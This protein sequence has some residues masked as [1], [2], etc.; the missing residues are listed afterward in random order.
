[1][2]KVFESEFKQWGKNMVKTH[3]FEA[4]DKEEWIVYEG[5]IDGGLREI[6]QLDYAKDCVLMD[7]EKFRSYSFRYV[8]P[9]IIVTETAVF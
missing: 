5:L 2:K 3:M 6:V 7:G 1:M 4:Q 9:H 8:E